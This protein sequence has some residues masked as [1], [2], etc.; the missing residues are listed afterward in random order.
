MTVTGSDV[1]P[2]TVV[3]FTRQDPAAAITN[4]D[5]LQFRVA[6]SEQVLNVDPSDF[7]VNG[8]TTAGIV[9]VVAVQGT[10]EAVYLITVSGGDLASFNGPVGVDLSS[11]N[12]IT[13]AALNALVNQEPLLDE[14]YTLDNIAPQVS[15]PIV[16]NDGSAQRSMVRS[17]TV[18]FDSAIV[19]QT[20]A[21]DLRTAGGQLINVATSVAPGTVTNQVVLTFPGQL[22]G[23]LLDGNYRLTLIGGLIFDVAGN[24][25]DG[26]A[27]G[28]AGGNRVDDFFRFFGDYDG[29]GDVDRRDY[30]FFQRAYKD[31]GNFYDNAFDVDTD[32]DID[33]RDYAFFQQNYGKTLG[34]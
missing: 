30:A 9:S 15:G 7:V 26:D 25:L 18:N 13:D 11:G 34:N 14:L 17:I 24:T 12:D 8:A 10:G 33:R 1:T 31:P 5:L 28:S 2:P 32:G 16:I 4:A 19:F 29:D 3:S 23:S 22:G 20:G 21:F 6:F 27:N